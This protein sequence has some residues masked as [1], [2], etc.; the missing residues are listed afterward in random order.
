MK[1][2]EDGWSD[3]LP[4]ELAFHIC[5]DDSVIR[6]Y[7]THVTGYLWKDIEKRTREYAL[8]THLS[9]QLKKP[10]PEKDEGDEYLKQHFAQ[11]YYMI[12]DEDMDVRPLGRFLTGEQ[13]MEQSEAVYPDY[14]GWVFTKENI[15]E[16]LEKVQDIE[17]K[18]K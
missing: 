18:N 16:I 8:N 3:P 15:L 9:F 5:N 17:N 1:Y 10:E 12:F 2:D 13:A 7:K 14:D 4:M 11:D 6:F